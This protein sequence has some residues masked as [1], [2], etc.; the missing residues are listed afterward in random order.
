M[1]RG[2]TETEGHRRRTA[3]VVGSGVAG[4]TAAWVLRSTYDVTLY[5]ADERLGGHAHTHDVPDPSGA[6]LAV[7]SGFIVHN[8][9]T[10]PLLL[11][12]FDEVGVETQAAEMSM[13]VRCD[14]CGLEYAGAR[15]VAGLVPRASHLA[16]GRYLRM[17][18]EIPR[19]HR[20]AR[21]LLASPPGA[22]GDATLGQFLAAGRWSRYFVEHFATPL[23]SCVWSCSP[24]TALDYPARYLFTF[25]AHHGML[26]V[27]GS[28]QWRTVV[29]GSRTYVERVAKELTAVHTGAAVRSL[30]RRPGG[31]DLLDAA[32]DTHRFDAAVVA[33]HPTQALALLAAPTGDE[34]DVL[35]AF[36]FSRNQAVLHRDGTLLPRSAGARASW[37]YRQERCGGTAER[38][39]VSYDLKRLQRLPAQ[40]DIVVSLNGGGGALPADDSV[41]ARM[42]YEHP[43]Y[44]PASVDARRR[45]PGL[46]TS[47]LAFAGAWTGWGFHEDGARSGVA[48][49]AALGVDW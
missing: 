28:P 38:V 20:A 26:G 21:R 43:L 22:T 44:T 29:G 6:T 39:R 27:S 2:Q 47:T 4:L 42:V 49:A 41:I 1:T 9:R 8:E 25:L 19:F 35:G 33:T 13:S 24:A 12:L 15:G 11:R 32:G 34:R 7:D 5:E 48:A 45:L 37:N 18:T 10:Y 46:N 36:H 30:S 3:A 23:V 17:L 40:G 16:R 31:V 14:G